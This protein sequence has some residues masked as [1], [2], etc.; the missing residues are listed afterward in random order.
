[1][2]FTSADLTAIIAKFGR[3]AAPSTLSTGE[4]SGSMAIPTSK[5]IQA[6]KIVI[7]CWLPYGPQTRLLERIGMTYDVPNKG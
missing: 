6:K 5:T 7:W 2:D 1:M 4:R 3:S